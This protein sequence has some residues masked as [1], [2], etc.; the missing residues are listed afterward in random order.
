M[1]KEKHEAWTCRAQS[2]M[3]D[4]FN[5]QCSDKGTKQ[6]TVFLETNPKR[7]YVNKI[8]FYFLYDEVT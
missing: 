4:S 7:S 8:K 5:R 6:S 3:P 1:S 2:G